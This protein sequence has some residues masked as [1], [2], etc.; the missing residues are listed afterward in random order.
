MSD[1]EAAKIAELVNNYT[2]IGYEN[3]IVV[4]KE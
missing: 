3:V 2:G 4:L 1:S